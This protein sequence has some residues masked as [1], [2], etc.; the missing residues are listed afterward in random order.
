MKEALYYSK[1]EEIENAVQCFLCPHECVI[2]EGKEGLC[3]VRKNE[4]GKLYS[5][6]YEEFSSSYMEPVEKKPLYHFYPGRR[7]LSLGTVGCNLRCKFCN[8]YNISQTGLEETPTHKMSADESVILAKEYLSLGI[9]YDY[10]EPIINFEYILE[11]MVKARR[12]G[13][14]NVLVT[15]GFINEKP[16]MDLLLYI[17]AVSV[18][19]KSFRND[20]YKTVCEGSLKPVLR[21]VEMIVKEGA[22]LEINVL[23]IP[24]LNDSVGE[25]EALVDWIYSLGPSIPLHFSRCFPAY[26]M[27]KEVTPLTSL[28]RAK[29]IAQKKLKFVYLENTWEDNFN[30]TYCP[31]CEELLIK[32]GGQGVRILN[33]NKNKCGKCGREINIIM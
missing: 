8:Q 1:T 16:L 11:G 18:D 30:D 17:D 14:K 13:L 10:N 15:N 20:F 4:R 21:T 7:I 24:E 3:Q 27:K 28:T 29:A 2:P 23:L 19:I 31:F 33:L 26:Q 9:A 5:L 32:R 25:L 12:Y 6:I 22:H